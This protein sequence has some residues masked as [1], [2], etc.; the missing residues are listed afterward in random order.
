MVMEIKITEE[1][2]LSGNKYNWILSEIRVTENMTYAV[3]TY[4]S[5]LR[6]VANKM[7][8]LVDISHVKSLEELASVYENFSDK[9]A[10]NLEI[11][12]TEI[13]VG[14]DTRP[15]DRVKL[16]LGPSTII[17]EIDCRGLQK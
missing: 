15:K 14:E 13:P 4:H 17:E 7:M 3:N 8:R 6:Q 11:A 12:S 1:F 2:I 10:E 16:G 5:T 9:I